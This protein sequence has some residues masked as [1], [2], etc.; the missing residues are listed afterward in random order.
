VE[1]KTFDYQFRSF[2]ELW[3]TVE[4]S[5]MLKQQ[6]D[7][8]PQNE[9][10]KIRDE[11]GR[12]ARF[13]PRRAIEDSARDI[14]W[15][16]REITPRSIFLIERDTIPT[17]RA[18]SLGLSTGIGQIGDTPRTKTGV[19]QIV[20]PVLVFAMVMADVLM[21]EQRQTSHAPAD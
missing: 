13:Y 7:A 20:N 15:Q 18:I 17:C 5:D 4:A 9:R 19:K 16:R 14:W 12:F 21:A 6:Y 10:G 11:V 2:E 8:L 3:D 1:S